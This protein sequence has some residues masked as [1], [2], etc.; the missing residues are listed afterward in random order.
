MSFSGLHSM[1][2]FLIF[3]LKSIKTGMLGSVTCTHDKEF[4]KQLA[5]EI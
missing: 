4:A 2:S 3:D 1:L 5:K